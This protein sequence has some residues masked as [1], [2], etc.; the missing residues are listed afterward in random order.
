[1]EAD[2]ARIDRLCEE[3]EAWIFELA[4]DGHRVTVARVDDDVRIVSA[5]GRDW[6]ATVPALL[7]ALRALPTSPLVM[8]GHLCALDESGRPSFDALRRCVSD[9]KHGP[10]VLAAWD[11]LVVGADDLGAQPLEA[12]RARLA[13]ILAAA[14]PS[15]LLSESLDGDPRALLGRLR[16]IGVRGLVARPRASLDPAPTSPLEWWCLS[17][18]AQKPVRWDRSLS[19]PASVTNRDKVLYPRDG[20]TKADVVAYYAHVAPVLLPYLRDR[21]VVA[22]RWPDGIDAFTWYQH[23]PPPRAPDYVRGFSFDG[24]RRL[25]LEDREALLWMVNQAALTF[26]GWTS[27]TRSVHEPDW[28]IL[29]L[30]PGEATR[31]EQTIEVALAVRR[32]L[33]LLEL[34]SVP[35][36]SGK[37][38]LH[39]LVPLAPGH[40]MASAQ[41]LAR[42]VASLVA[43]LAPDVVCLSAEPEER[44]GR[45]YLDHQ[46]GYPGK[47][48][49]LPYALRDVD[50]APVSTPLAWDEVTP[51]LD[52]GAFT[53]RTLARRL[54]RVGDLARPLLG[55]GVSIAA[56][57][58][59][60]SRSSA[61]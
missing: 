21:G 59:R 3:R 56:A 16:A 45:L 23:R 22:Q 1:M 52:P 8:E 32:L 44:R 12:R 14:S 61:P 54:D 43:R 24:D 49:V 39:V 18:D 55:P 7:R 51:R 57:L 20:L 46:Q 17:T 27:R 2:E 37:K 11:V 4:W 10:V 40:D 36:T 41:S 26:H 29:D 60:L 33:E 48:L 53:L 30:D 28:A 50:G 47:T 38:G 13:T 19:P 42:H 34:P 15:L 25:L 5:D 31:W 58:A 6:S 9:P 35:K